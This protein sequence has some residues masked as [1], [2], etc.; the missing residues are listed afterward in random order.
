MAEIA[1]VEGGGNVGLAHAVAFA[2]L[3]HDVGGVDTDGVKVA[4]L[5]RGHSPNHEVGLDGH[6]Q[7]GLAGVLSRASAEFGGSCFPRGRACFGPNGAGDQSRPSHSQRGGEINV[8]PQGQVVDKFMWCLGDLVCRTVAVVGPAFKTDT[9]D[10]REAP[11]LDVVRM[12][13]AVGM[14]VR[15]TGLAGIANAAD[16][17]PGGEFV[18]DPYEAA[19]G[20]DALLLLTVWEEC[21]TL[22]LDHLA[23]AMRGRL[24]VDGRN[25]L[26]PAAVTAAGLTWVGVGRPTAEL[27]RL[28]GEE[29]H[30]PPFG[31]SRPAKTWAAAAD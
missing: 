5:T 21:R 17:V 10:V 11:S 30:G 29:T 14:R 16:E 3:G 20:A 18:G 22:D 7:C 31:R 8:N 12:L 6:L 19:M 9:G 27:M 2:E 23:N 24:V 4:A 25:A 26:D 13:L 1:I 28:V 15:A